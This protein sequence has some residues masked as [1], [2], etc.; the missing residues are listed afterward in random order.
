MTKRDMFPVL[1]SSRRR[2]ASYLLRDEF[3]T[4]QPAPLTS[5]RTCEPGPGTAKIV[6]TGNKLSISGGRIVNAGAV[7]AGDPSISFS[8]FARSTGM[9]IV[10]DVTKKV[11]SATFTVGTDTVENG[12]LL[13]DV[14][15]HC[16]FFG[17]G[18]GLFAI[19]AQG[20]SGVIGTH[21]DETNY[22]IAVVLRSAGGFVLIKGGIYSSWTLL[23]IT[24]RV[25]NATIYPTITG[26]NTSVWTSGYIRRVQLG[27]LWQSS[28]Y[29]ISTGYTASPAS[30][31]ELTHE[32]DCLSSVLWTAATNATLE[33][34]IRRTDADNRWIVRCD[35]AGGTIK[36]I[37]REGGTETERS[38]AAQ[39]W[40]NNT[41]YHILIAAYGS[42]IDVHV[43][44]GTGALKN[45]YASATFN[46]TAT[47]AK[48]TASAGA[49]ANFATW[50][51]TLS[52]AALAALEAV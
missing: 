20:I 4:D 21:A 45:T 6:D 41:Q 35:Q 47:S 7:T 10:A 46:Q 13:Q 15:L 19:E 5:P 49:L 33:F 1:F 23:Y 9:A 27:G 31:A 28:D 22:T 51:R 11:S 16:S 8:S 42:I 2:A 25:T 39:T 52:G 34:D 38:S 24:R 36:L 29:G 32:A 3:T 40:T 48:I 43:G 30:G 12:W 18:G 14:G 17:S 26:G 44:T 37:Q 50:P